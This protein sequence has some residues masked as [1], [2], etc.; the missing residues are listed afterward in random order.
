[1]DINNQNIRVGF[2]MFIIIFAFGIFIS[3]ARSFT[4]LWLY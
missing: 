3:P 1:M 4:K 2:L